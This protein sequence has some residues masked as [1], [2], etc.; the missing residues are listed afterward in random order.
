MGRMLLKQHECVYLCPF[1]LQRDG[2]EAIG[3]TCQSW[4]VNLPSLGGLIDNNNKLSS[5]L[6]LDYSNVLTGSNILFISAAGEF[7][8]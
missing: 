1:R 6:V 4:L 5:Q 7:T 8:P 2:E 3:M